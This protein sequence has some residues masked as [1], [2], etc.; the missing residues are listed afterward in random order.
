MR[1]D[2]LG[3]T[4]TIYPG[5]RTDDEGP[6]VGSRSSGERP[7]VGH[8]RR[9]AARRASE[10]KTAL[11]SLDKIDPILERNHLV[12]GWLDRDA[13]LVV[14]GPSNVGK[15]FFALDLALHVAAG[16]DWYGHRV[17][18]ADDAG[19]PVVYVAAEEEQAF[20]T[21]W[22]PSAVKSWRCTPARLGAAFTCSR[23]A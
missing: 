3:C 9:E 8:I 23:E 6:S 1:S 16:V 22:L 11:V 21:A 19:A 12:K 15:T 2:A 10:L 5:R 14:Y 18:T 20:A 7:L 13:T 17:R 4:S